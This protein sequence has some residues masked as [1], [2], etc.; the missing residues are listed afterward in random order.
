MMSPRSMT[1][2]LARFRIGSDVASR[3]ARDA[4]RRP[5]R[6][7]LRLDPLEERTL[8]S[9]GMLDPSFGLGG[10]VLTNIGIPTNDRVE[11]SMT[12]VQPDGKILVAGRTESGTTR[13]DFGV[14]RYNTDGSLD[15][16]FGD[17]GSVAIDFGN[18]RDDPTG[19]ALDSQ[20]R[21]VIAGFTTELGYSFD[22][23]VARLEADG[24]LDTSFAGGG[25]QTINFGY[26]KER[27]Y[28]VAVDSQ[29]RVVLVGQNDSVGA[30]TGYDFF[31]AQ[32]KADGTL[33]TS[34]AG[35]G[36]QIVDIG[37]TD[38]FATG[39]AVDGQ[40]RIIVTGKSIDKQTGLSDFGGRG[41]RPTGHSTPASLATVRG[42]STLVAPTI[43]H[44]RDGGRSGSGGRRWVFPSDRHRAPDFAV[45]RL[46]VDGT[47]DSSFSGDGARTVDF[48]GTDDQAHGV[49]VDN[50]DRVIIA[51]YS[52]QSGTGYDFAVARLDAFGALDQGFDGDGKQ[53]VDLGNS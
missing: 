31:V 1:R 12:V 48:G 45:A 36:T 19:L 51:G 15:R 23:A 8:L 21:V 30:A 22:Y 25:K 41:W 7:P 9:T 43:G 17:G 29:D 4:R 20:G 18:T 42:P 40:D 24:T 52:Y 16:S 13:T 5:I 46:E 47:L 3:R 34:F 53:T 11:Y 2:T 10:K 6:S 33:D 32:L 49:A 35:D 38:D 44:R 28:A 37:N 27:A 14:A 39:V 50:Q 26:Y